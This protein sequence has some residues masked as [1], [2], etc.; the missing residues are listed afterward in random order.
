MV[1]KDQVVSL[2]IRKCINRAEGKK[3]RKR[4]GVF[5]TTLKKRSAEETCISQLLRRTPPSGKPALVYSPR[6]NKQCLAKSLASV[7]VQSPLD[8]SFI[9]SHHDLLPISGE[10]ASRTKTITI[11]IVFMPSIGNHLQPQKPVTKTTP[12][13]FDR[14]P[15]QCYF[16]IQHMNDQD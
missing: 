8:V 7:A 10:H 3:W 6:S 4:A 9:F 5:N 14:P 12:I 11:K 16:Q 2:K 1:S 13:P 15:T